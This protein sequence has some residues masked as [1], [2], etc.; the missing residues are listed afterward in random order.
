MVC[1]DVHHGLG[2]NCMQDLGVEEMLNGIDKPRAEEPHEKVRVAS[3]Y[4]LDSLKRTRRKGI[5]R[6]TMD[7]RRGCFL[8]LGV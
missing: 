7:Q 6:E 5:A 4:S 3:K 8:V 2:L 1:C